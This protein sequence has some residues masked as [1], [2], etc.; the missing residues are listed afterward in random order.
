MGGRHSHTRIV[1]TL[2]PMASQFSGVT[3]GSLC[4]HGVLGIPHEEV[5]KKSR[6][7]HDQ[8]Y[9][10]NIKKINHLLS[11]TKYCNLENICVFKNI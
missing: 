7:F 9:F 10:H 3:T 11:A 8:D 4:A 1:W 2:P 5:R 6:G